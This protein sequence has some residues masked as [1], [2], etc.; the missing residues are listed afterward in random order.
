MNLSDSPNLIRRSF[1]TEPNM[2]NKTKCVD[3]LSYLN[4]T[5]QKELRDKENVKIKICKK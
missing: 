1:G 4:V 2:N 3:I 5:N